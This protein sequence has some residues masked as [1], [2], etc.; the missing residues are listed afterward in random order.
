MR[1]AARVLEN[2]RGFY[3]ENVIAIL[4]LKTVC[5]M[6]NKIVKMI[7]N[8]LCIEGQRFLEYCGYLVALNQCQTG[9]YK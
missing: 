3:N 9:L 6:L 5:M 2:G 8:F 7:A 4:L 1:R